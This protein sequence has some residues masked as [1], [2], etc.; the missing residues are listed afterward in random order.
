[1][2][3]LYCRK[4]RAV[5]AISQAA[6]DDFGWPQAARRVLES[7]DAVLSAG[8]HGHAPRRRGARDGLIARV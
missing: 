7:F 1:M 4:A 5:L 8:P 3:P 2:L 6:L